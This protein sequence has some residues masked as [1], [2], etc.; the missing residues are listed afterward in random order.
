MSYLLNHLLKLCNLVLLQF[1]VV[2]DRCYLN[3]ALGFRLWWLKWTSEYGHSSIIDNLLI[4]S[5]P[6]LN[7]LLLVEDLVESS[8][9]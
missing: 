4:N 6:H 1:L 7:C 9:R 5:Y 3:L 8:S 2:C